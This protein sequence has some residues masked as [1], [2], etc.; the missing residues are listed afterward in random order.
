MN[1]NVNKNN[2]EKLNS[3]QQVP[4]RPQPTDLQPSSRLSPPTKPLLPKTQQGLNLEDTQKSIEH[5]LEGIQPQTVRN[6][7]R[8][9][10][11]LQIPFLSR[12]FGTSKPVVQQNVPQITPPTPPVQPPQVKAPPISNE[13]AFVNRFKTQINQM[14]S[15]ACT[16]ATTFSGQI[17]LKKS[18]LIT[19]ITTNRPQR[20]ENDENRKAYNR[21]ANM[22]ALKPVLN[23]EDLRKGHDMVL[24]AEAGCCSTFALAATHI[25][26]EGV[27]DINQ[28]KPRVEMVACKSGSHGSHCFVIVGRA[29]NSDLSDPKTWGEN[30]LIVDPW[31]ASLGHDHLFTVETYPKESRSLL[32][33]DT[34][35]YDSHQ[36]DPIGTK[37]GFEKA[38]N[39]VI[40]NA[41]K[42]QPVNEIQTPETESED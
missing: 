31:L 4:R 9:M 21:A 28:E 25:L 10:Q 11:R 26:T 32:S 33:A 6:N 2:L 3:V 37:I 23:Q 34:Q 18:Y 38:P 41:H 12:F 7:A 19:E 17:N 13:L 24:R 8:R 30:A 27:R 36:P 42:L 15:F 16:D 39:K 20:F 22:T 1:L 5:N 35:Q 40:I 29:P 14:S